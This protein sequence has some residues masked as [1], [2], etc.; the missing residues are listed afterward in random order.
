MAVV[1]RDNYFDWLVNFVHG[2]EYRKILWRL[3]L[4]PFYWEDGV[5]T[6]RNRA[7]DG[8]KLR[9]ENGGT[10]WQFDEIDRCSVL[11][12]LIAMAIRCEDEIM[13]VNGMG[14]RTIEWFWIMLD[15]LEL[16]SLKLEEDLADEVFEASAEDYIHN[17]LDVFTSRSYNYDGSNGGL[18]KVEKP[19]FDMRKADLWLQL[20]W[21]LTEHY[22]Y[23][24]D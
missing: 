7:L 5:G 21:W 19:R 23:E 12:M 24:C 1:K 22:N 11:E 8:I 6:D 16:Y 14:D 2:D 9:E 10:G 20:N 4:Y 15:N 17:I 13:A 18:F 3:Y